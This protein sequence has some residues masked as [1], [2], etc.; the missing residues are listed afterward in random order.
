ME[1]LTDLSSDDSSLSLISSSKSLHLMYKTFQELASWLQF[2]AQHT[3]MR[4]CS[5][6]LLIV[7]V[8]A[9]SDAAPGMLP[10]SDH[11]LWRLR[12]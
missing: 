12:R 8:D 4:I 3:S 2:G 7:E 11:P 6:Q 10:E 1:S 5:S 9:C